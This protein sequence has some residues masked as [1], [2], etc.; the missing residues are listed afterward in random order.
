[1]PSKNNSI[2]AFK[3]PAAEHMAEEYWTEERLRSVAPIQLPCRAGKVG[4]RR[5]GA[6]G[7]K[8]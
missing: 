1:M 2:V 4:W 8:G 6:Q 5:Q 7:A 3:R